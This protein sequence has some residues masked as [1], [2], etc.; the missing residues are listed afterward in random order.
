MESSKSI[1]ARKPLTVEEEDL[2]KKDNDVFD[3]VLSFDS[4]E[5]D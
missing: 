2:F 3:H 5:I 1:K 4:F